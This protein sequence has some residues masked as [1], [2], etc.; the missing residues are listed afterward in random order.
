M[1]PY[2]T[3]TPDQAFPLPISLVEAISPDDPVHVVREVVSSLDLSA[4]HQSY[5]CER[6][7]PPFNPQAMVGLLLYGACRGSYSSGRLAQ[8]CADNVTFMYLTG[9]LRPD[10]HTIA[11][12][13]QALSA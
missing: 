8:G 13:P 6:G 1:R 10:F 3:Y 11:S 2:H 5:R 4:I 12:F 7:R 9:Q